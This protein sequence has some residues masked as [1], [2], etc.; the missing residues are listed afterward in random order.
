MDEATVIFVPTRIERRKLG[1]CNLVPCSI[2]L[3]ANVRND[4]TSAPVH[5]G[6]EQVSRLQRTESDG[7]VERWDCAKLGAAVGLES[8]RQ[9][10]GDFRHSGIR[11]A[12]KLSGYMGFQTFFKASSEQGINE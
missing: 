10:A 8:A 6:V 7:H 12:R 2:W 1:R 4:Q 5:R 9:V 3:D 11:Q